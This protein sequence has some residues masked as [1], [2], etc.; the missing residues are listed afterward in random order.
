MRFGFLL[1]FAAVLV[2]VAIA[3]AAGLSYVF[4]RSHLAAVRSDLVAATIGQASAKLQPALNTYAAEGKMA[5]QTRATLARAILDIENFQELVRNVRIFSPAGVALDPS[6]AQP[7]P[8]FARRAITDQNVVTSPAFERDGDQLETV[9]VP[10]GASNAT[11]YVAVVAIDI[12][13]GQLD[14]QTHGETRFV[15]SATIAAVALIILSLLILAITAQREL[16]KRRRIANT[17]FLQTMEGIAA[18][19][20]QRDPYTAGHSRRVAAYSVQV[21]HRLGEVPEQVE[22]VRTGALLHD[23][24]KIGIS[25]AVLLKPD[26][27]DRDER[28]LIN[29]HPTLARKILEPVEAMAPIVPCVLHHHE[30]WDGTGYP[31][32]LAGEAIPRLARIIAVADTFD[33]ITTN[34]PYRTSL[35]IAEARK[36]LLEGRGTQWDAQCV[37]AI[38]ALIDADEMQLDPTASNPV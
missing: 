31:D 7:E 26:R 18:I 12:S 27:L 24:G 4:A 19:V 37:D 16:D 32:G 22:L 5:P 35:S 28:A 15:I 38:V 23:L 3:A 20:D 2:L 13:L 9:Y 36:R 11:G 1:R 17:T 30:R 34:R 10:T 14:L 6:S 21:A 33:A 29:G 25:D 8:A